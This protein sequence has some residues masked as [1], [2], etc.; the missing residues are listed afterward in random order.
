MLLFLCCKV[1]EEMSASAMR[2]AERDRIFVDR[3][4]QFYC[5]MRC[6]SVYCATYN[7]L[8][9]LGLCLEDRKWQRKIVRKVFNQ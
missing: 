4:K 6:S 3:R 1:G 9:F 7:K 5:K 2:K 8:I